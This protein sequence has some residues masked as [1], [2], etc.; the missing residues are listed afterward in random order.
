MSKFPINYW[1]ITL[2]VGFMMYSWMSIPTNKQFRIQ[3]DV[4]FIAAIGAMLTTSGILLSKK[5]S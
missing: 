1:L 4:I 2:G 3:P 5:Q